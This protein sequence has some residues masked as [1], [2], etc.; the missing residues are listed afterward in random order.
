MGVLYFT[1]GISEF[2][3]TTCGG[4]NHSLFLD[5]NWLKNI[6]SNSVLSRCN[7][8]TSRKLMTCLTVC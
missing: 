2:I 4:P 8:K 3:S 6:S 5:I 1:I 7:A